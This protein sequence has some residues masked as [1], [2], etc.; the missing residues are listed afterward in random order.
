MPAHDS[1]A[2]ESSPDSQDSGDSKSPSVAIPDEG[3]VAN[4]S[5]SE[6][7]ATASEATSSES[8]GSEA[9]AREATDVQ[10]AGSEATASEGTDLEAAG[11]GATSPEATNL[12]AAGSDTAVSEAAGSKGAGSDA[13]G[14]Q[15]TGSEH[16]SLTPSPPSSPLRGIQSTGSFEFAQR[17]TTSSHSSEAAAS[18]VSEEPL[19]QNGHPS[20]SHSG[21]ASG[22]ISSQSH[23]FSEEVSSRQSSETSELLSE[24]PEQPL[25]EELAISLPDSPV[26]AA[27][28]EDFFTPGVH[29]LG[30]MTPSGGLPDSPSAVRRSSF[31]TAAD[32][33]GH[34][35]GG[36]K[37]VSVFQSSKEASKEQQQARADSLPCT[38]GR[39]AE[40]P[41][42]PKRRSSCGII[43]GADRAREDAE[44][45]DDAKE[46][47]LDARFQILDASDVFSL[48]DGRTPPLA[49]LDSF[50]PISLAK[51]V[52]MDIQQA[53]LPSESAPMEDSQEAL[54]DTGADNKD[55]S[56]ESESPD[57]IR[58]LRL[59]DSRV[60]KELGS[61][62]GHSSDVS[63]QKA[64][65]SNKNR[66]RAHSK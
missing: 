65:P 8:A 25:V 34:L 30:Q 58:R 3:G 42:K 14:S 50:E 51:A 31:V 37:P 27:R 13:T 15:A 39:I 10:A 24:P 12:E 40:Q 41:Q 52:S 11:S 43:R 38:S 57:N 9:M 45:S 44:L 4:Q 53:A 21:R 22:E 6:T 60:Q 19:Q 49:D 23:K 66:R 62:N 20:T 47:S 54:S 7:E 64:Q 36:L 63:S 1:D 32:D 55:S 29:E 18:K 33:A 35:F 59:Q 17:C 56:S 48:S 5:R 26:E 46:D 16:S 28:E 2:E 61:R